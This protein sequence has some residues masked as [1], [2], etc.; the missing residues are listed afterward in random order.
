MRIAKIAPSASVVWLP[1][2]GIFELLCLAVN[3]DYKQSLAWY[4]TMQVDTKRNIKWEKSKKHWQTLK[5]LKLDRIFLLYNYTMP[6]ARLN[7]KSV[8]RQFRP[9]EGQRK[10]TIL[11]NLANEFSALN[12]MGSFWLTGHGTFKIV[13]SKLPMD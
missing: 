12:M 5:Y 8:I 1:V 2:F 11:Y 7:H 4:L 6:F 3:S 13:L 10:A 9:K